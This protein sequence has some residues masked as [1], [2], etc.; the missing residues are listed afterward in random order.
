MLGGNGS[1][2]GSVFLFDLDGFPSH[3]HSLVGGFNPSE[4][5]WSKWESSPN[6]SENK[7]YLKSPVRFNL[8]GTI[9]HFNENTS[10]FYPSHPETNPQEKDFLR[11]NFGRFWK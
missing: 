7:E 4:K 2:T 3:K 6:R 9:G 8:E 5:Y 11:P 1:H 10:N